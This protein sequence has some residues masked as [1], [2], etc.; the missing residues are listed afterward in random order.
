MVTDRL[1]GVSG[2]LTGGGVTVK[3][4]FRTDGSCKFDD[5]EL[6]G[7]QYDF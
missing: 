3:F 5:I 2:S 6:A 1:G 7:C 4:E